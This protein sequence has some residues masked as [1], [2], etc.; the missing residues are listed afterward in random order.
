[1][2]WPGQPAALIICVTQ[3]GNE[4]IGV[5]MIPVPGGEVTVVVTLFMVSA[6]VIVVVAGFSELCQCS[7]KILKSPLQFTQYAI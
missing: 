4:F 1:M 3:P 2:A 5:F 7:T 6:I